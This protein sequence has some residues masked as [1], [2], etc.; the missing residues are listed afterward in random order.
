MVGNAGPAAPAS[1]KAESS[2][3][4]TPALGPLDGNDAWQYLRRLKVTH[5]LYLEECKKNH[6]LEENLRAVLVAYD[7]PDDRVPQAQLVASDE[8]VKGGSYSSSTV[9]IVFSTPL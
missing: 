8:R 4:E 7:A 3:E 5:D 6:Q 1:P 9:S 2:E